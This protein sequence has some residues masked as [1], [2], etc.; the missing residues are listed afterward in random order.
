[1]ATPTRRRYALL[2]QHYLTVRPY[3]Y[4]LTH[5]NNLNN[6]RKTGQLFPALTLMQMGGREDLIRK[7]R[8][9]HVSVSVD[10]ETIFLRDQHP[11][12]A[13][14]AKFPRGY[15]FEDLVENLNR[16]V[17]FWPGTATTIVTSGLNH[18]ECYR[19]EKPIL[20]RVK[21]QSLLDS[22]PGATPLFCQ[23][24]SGSPRCVHGERSPRGP[25]TFISAE[26]FRYT[27]SRVVEVTFD[28]HL[29]LPPDTEFGSRPTGPWQLLR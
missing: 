18:F 11:L 22:N 9:G 10:G 15:S 12:H 13:G 20:L 17:F 29:M 16:R 2:T 26:D 28:S 19:Q 27:P 4:H 21:F 14:N 24:N 8:P 5:K 7:R 6:L 1:M 25:K 3:L 23:F